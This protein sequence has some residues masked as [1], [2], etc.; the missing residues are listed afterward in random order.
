MMSGA[1]KLIKDCNDI[2]FM[3]GTTKLIKDCNDI[4]FIGNYKID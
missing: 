1:T 4:I 2:I 3:S